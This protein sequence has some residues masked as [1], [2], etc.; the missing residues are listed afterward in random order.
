MLI[1]LFLKEHG[2]DLQKVGYKK[3]TIRGISWIGSFRIVTRA[4]SFLRTAILAR[5]LSPLDFGMFG[6]ATLVLAFLEIITETGINIILVQKKEKIDEYIDTA[7]VTSIARGFLIFLVIFFSTPF[8]VS[9]FNE[10]RAIQLL[11]II[12][13]VPLIRGFINPS[14]AKFVKDLDFKKEFIYRTSIFAVESIATLLV[15][16]LTHN[17]YGL[18]FGLLVGALFEVLLSFVI[19]RPLPKFK[20]EK[21]KLLEIVGKGKWLTATGVL[22]YLY[23]NI[24]DVFVA[25]LVSVSSFGLYDMAYRISMLP[26]TEVS[27]VIGRVTFPVF[28]KM[29]DE[30]ERLQKAYLKSLLIIFA[31]VTPMGIIFYLFPTE[32]IVILLGSHWLEAA[33]VLQVLA[34]FGVSRALTQSTI[35]PLYA[36]E[37]QD[38]ITKISI[39]NLIAL[40]IFIYPLTRMFGI[41]GA[42][43]AAL[44]A[45]TISIPYIF[46]V[47]RKH[48]F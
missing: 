15:V 27:D 30:K 42:A 19:I 24:D 11:Y 28:V 23:Q 33:K 39:L 21:E 14:V 29:N 25:K 10:D 22:Q 40:L 37:K 7:W 41:V 31:L 44:L 3:D 43:Y 20:F 26:I 16:V 5:F 18:V 17:I 1:L 38:A 45:N 48:L 6:I 47:V 46:Y 8:I 13:L 35:A 9:F 32:I 34:F 2:K 12:S 4:I 36:L